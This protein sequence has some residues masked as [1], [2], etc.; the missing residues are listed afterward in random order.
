MNWYYALGD[1]RKGPVADLE[2][3]LLAQQ[4]TIKPDTLVWREGMSDWQPWSRVSTASA[5]STGAPPAGVLCAGCGGQFAVGDVVNIGGGFYCTQC[6]PLALQRL[7]EGAV[8]APSAVEQLRKDHLKHEASVQSVGILY[9]L[10]GG[11]LTVGGI[12]GFAAAA[13]RTD[14]AAV[15]ISAFLLL[16]GIGQILIGTGLRRLRPW[17]RVPAAILSGIG[18]LGFPIGTIINAY[19]LYLIL[20]AKGK[21]VFSQEY[22]AVIDQTPHIKYR[23][24]LVVWVVFILLVLLIIFGL[25]AAILSSNR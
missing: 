10:G 25:S 8:S 20:C 15:V 7:K 18:L 5:S 11:A 9:Y 16:M 6:K 22:R 2:F 12:I 4:G 14:V 17:A 13:S 3:Q 23:T 19:I 24:S 21:M 1:E